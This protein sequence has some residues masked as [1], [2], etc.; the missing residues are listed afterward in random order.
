MTNFLSRIFSRRQAATVPSMDGVL[1][2]NDALDHI[3]T[4]STISAPDNLVV[5]KSKVIGSSGADLY[6]VD[7]AKNKIGSKPLHHFDSAVTA[8]AASPKGALAVGLDAHGI[9]IVGG[10]HDGVALE[11]LGGQSASCITSLLFSGEDTLFV[12]L[13]S[14]QNSAEN[15][16]RDLLEKRS[17][18][19]VWQVDLKTQQ[20][21]RIAANLAYPNGLLLRGD[22]LTVSES[23]NHRLLCFGINGKKSPDLA[24]LADIPGYPG[25]L[26]PAADGGAWLAV[27]APRSQLIEFVL[28]ED[29]YRNRMMRELSSEYWI[30]PTYRAGVSFSEPMQG[31]AVK[32][33]GIHKAWAPTR[34][35]GLLVLLDSN[36]A[37]VSS[38]HSRADGHRHGI[39]S[40]CELN[41][42]VIIACRGDN[43][44]CSMPVPQLAMEG[45]A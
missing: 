11:K 9:K 15:W 2:P 18:G 37:P 42:N 16:Q 8:L 43:A 25:R 3:K 41:G 40:A 35:Y 34:S 30:A 12:C 28:R 14:S 31:G 38:Y 19:S 27:F 10:S 21:N 32:V 29:A 33:H 44:V 20:A 5:V 7:A 13:G 39:V 17:S 23:W 24:I 1:R 36:L 45:D 26:S 22:M 4:I 6:G